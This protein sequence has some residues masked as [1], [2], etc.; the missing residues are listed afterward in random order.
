M[1]AQRQVTI[2][3]EGGASSRRRSGAS[4]DHRSHAYTGFNQRVA[5]SRTT[6][7]GIVLHE[8]YPAMFARVAQPPLVRDALARLLAVDGGHGV[9]DEAMSTQRVG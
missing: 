5:F 9:D 3:R 7:D 6:P 1:S 4:S 8:H 2:G